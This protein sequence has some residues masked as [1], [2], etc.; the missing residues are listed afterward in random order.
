MGNKLFKSITMGCGCKNNKTPQQVDQQKAKD[1]VQQ[2]Q[3]QNAVKET[4]LKYY[5]KNK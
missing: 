5:Q 3:V 1:Q 2:K 4:I